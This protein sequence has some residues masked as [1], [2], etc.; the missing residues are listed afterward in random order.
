MILKGDQEMKTFK[1]FPIILK[2]KLAK[3]AFPKRDQ[4]REN[5]K[6][7]VKQLFTR[8]TKVKRG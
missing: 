6:D 4:D 5:G 2:Y 7:E 1:S 8:G 3:N